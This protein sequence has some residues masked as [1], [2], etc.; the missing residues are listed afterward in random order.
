[1]TE[2]EEPAAAPT[3]SIRPKSRPPK[4]VRV[5]ET[6]AETPA[7]ENPAAPR[8]DAVDAALAEALGDTGQGQAA[9]KPP[10]PS[11]P[12][13]TS[14][15]K[16]EFALAVKKCWVVDPG[17]E[18][19]SI[20]VDIGFELTQ[21]GKVVSSTLR[22]IRASDGSEGAVKS[23]YEA[24]RRAILRCGARGFELPPEK[25]AQWREVEIS[26]NPENMRIK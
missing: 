17:S 6:P 19:A 22:M 20:V 9:E 18:S 16:G 12:P 25:Y 15:E 26:F 4:P 13:L 11:G 10:I 7:A 3:A 5:A 2:A 21:D 8:V 24:G 23:A 1:V 14:G